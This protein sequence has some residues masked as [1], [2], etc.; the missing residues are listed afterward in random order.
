M[1]NYQTTG[2]V[3]DADVEFRL[4]RMGIA[5]VGTVRHP[6]NR[7]KVDRMHPWNR[8]PLGHLDLVDCNDCHG[9]GQLHIRFMNEPKDVPC[10]TCEGFG[11]VSTWVPNRV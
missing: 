11:T 4:Q 1:T 2:D 8:K 3:L 5:P 7:N 10:P 9:E 6:S